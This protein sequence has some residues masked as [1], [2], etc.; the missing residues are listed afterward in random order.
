MDV[1]F[2]LLRAV[3]ISALVALLGGLVFAIWVVG[4]T[5]EVR[6]V[7]DSDM[8][9]RLIRWS[10]SW[11]ALA[12]VSGAGWLGFEAVIMSGL[13]PAQALG[14]ETLSV[15]LLQT[16]F[17]RVWIARCVLCL[18]LAALLLAC[19]R[20]DAGRR[21]IVVLMSTA[22]AAA[23]IATLA[24][25]GHA[26][27]EHGPQ[28]L[29]HLAADAAHLLAAGAWVGALPALIAMIARQRRSP[30]RVTLEDVARATQRFSLLGVSSVG[31][32]IASGGV[33]AWFTVGT[34]GALFMTHYGHLLL[35][36]LALFGGMLV[37]AAVNRVR[38]TKLLSDTEL[39]QSV[40]AAAQRSLQRNATLEAVL[41]LL[42]IGIVGALG[43]TMPAAHSP[44]MTPS[45]HMSW[46]QQPTLN[47]SYRSKVESRQRHILS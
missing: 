27:S 37:L 14:G 13:P 43:T 45:M 4:A 22:V 38:L 34:F 11:L 16:Q 9:A 26:N 32:L 24:L 33:N 6:V 47:V 42:V 10:A 5:A 29:V 31:V 25:A 12:F 7:G 2:I 1:A 41:A 36:K 8:H 15:V 21:R 44:T 30:E 17:G 39:S 19:P 28:R 46:V 3:H 18:I 20:A 35:V 23:L 40:R